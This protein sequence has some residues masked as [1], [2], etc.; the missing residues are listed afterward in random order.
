MVK[1]TSQVAGALVAVFLVL[2]GC[3]VEDATEAP[4]PASDLRSEYASM[5]SSQS[6]S[7]ATRPVLWDPCTVPSSALVAA[8]L[9]T[10]TTSEGLPYPGGSLRSCS[11]QGVDSS[12]QRFSSMVNVNRLSFDQQLTNQNHHDRQMIEM[13]PGRP[14]YVAYSSSVGRLDGRAVVVWGIS[15]GSISVSLRFEGGRP[16]KRELAKE[17]VLPFARAVFKVAPS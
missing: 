11:W 5:T 7:A 6:P 8:G 10:S 4:V 13:A 14:G 12:G 9:D 2:V 16:E 1:R 3:A 17:R 15:D